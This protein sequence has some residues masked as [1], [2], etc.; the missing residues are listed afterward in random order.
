[1][2]RSLY[3]VKIETKKKLREEKKLV[4]VYQR[5]IY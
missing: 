4:I 3:R 2:L 5:V 1:M